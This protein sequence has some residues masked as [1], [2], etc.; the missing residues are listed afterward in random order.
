MKIRRYERNGGMKK[1]S[2]TI[3]NG[4]EEWEGSILIN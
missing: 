3:G 1:N 2:L 4:R